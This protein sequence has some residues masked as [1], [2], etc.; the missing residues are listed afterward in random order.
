M[1][2]KHSAA[3]F[4]GALFVLVACTSR[5]AYC[6]PDPCSLL[7]QA[8]VSAALGVQVGEGRLVVPTICE[9]AAPG[10]SA[11]R[12]KKVL[13]TLQ[14]PQAFA[15]A[16]MPVGHGITKTPVS[17]IGDDAVYGTT[18]GAPTV[19]TVKKG[20]VVFVVHVTGL[21]DDQTKAKEKTLALEILSKL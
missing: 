2:T 21:P 18:P 3:L 6:A 5:P 20:N 12:A 8:H 10:E 7:T 11:P 15:Y 17:G 9:W 13:I 16:K 4:I 14:G 1:N 19:L